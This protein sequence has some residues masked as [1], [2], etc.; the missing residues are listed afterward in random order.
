MLTL[1]MSVE[2]MFLI[3][4][5]AACQALKRL[6]SRMNSG[7]CL[8]FR[9]ITKSL[10]ANSALKKL[11]TRMIFGAPFQITIRKPLFA[12]RGLFISR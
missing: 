1:G 10:T 6:L 4:P 7:M 11:V 2:M 12:N 8:Q 5:L 3:K 9:F